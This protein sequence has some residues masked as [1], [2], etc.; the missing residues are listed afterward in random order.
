MWCA[1]TGHVPGSDD[2][3]GVQ[4]LAANLSIEKRRL[5]C[6]DAKE[7]NDNRKY[8]YLNVTLQP[9]TLKRVIRAEKEEARRLRLHRQG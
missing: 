7:G 1:D 2:N 3:L 6:D 9:E 5:R 8:H 4:L